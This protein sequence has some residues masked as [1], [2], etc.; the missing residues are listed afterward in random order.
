MQQQQQQ[1]QQQ[2][3]EEMFYP[4]QS[5]QFWE[6]TKPKNEDV[7]V[8]TISFFQIDQI[9][10]W[11]TDFRYCQNSQHTHTHTHFNTHTLTPKAVH[12]VFELN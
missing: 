3:T 1:Q 2:E 11:S 10:G 7:A 12:L 8:V 9:L 4:L 6:Q 5:F